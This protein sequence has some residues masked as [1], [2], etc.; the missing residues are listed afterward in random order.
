DTT[1]SS[2][3]AVDRAGKPLAL[4]PEF[5]ENPNAM[6]ILWKDHTAIK[7]AEEI[8]QLA[9]TWGGADFTQYSGGIYSSEWLWSK[10]PHVI[11]Q[12]P[13]VA[14]AAYSWMAH[15]DFMAYER[16]GATKPEEFKRRRCAGGDE[17]LWH[18]S[19]GGLPDKAFVERRDPPLPALKDRL[20]TET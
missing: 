11:R 14:D 3:M 1:G 18:G 2:P 9:R 4:L 13:R 10:I 17:A 20:Y 12:D 7:E 8:N 5:S 6:L 16:V 15:C 19:W